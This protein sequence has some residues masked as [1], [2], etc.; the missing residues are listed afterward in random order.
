MTAVVELRGEGGQAGAAAD[1]ADEQP[2]VAVINT[3]NDL[4]AQELVMGASNKYTADEQIEQIAFYWINLHE[5]AA[6]AAD[7]PHSRVRNRDVYLDLAGGNR[8]P[9][10]S[11]RQARSVAELRGGRRRPPRRAG[12]RPDKHWQRPFRRRV[13]HARSAR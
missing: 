5:G 1:R 12:P 13:D 8:I 7:D 11:E 2:A 4:Q 6:A 10:I 9:K 3:A